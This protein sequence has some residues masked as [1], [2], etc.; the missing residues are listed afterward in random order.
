MFGVTVKQGGPDRRSADTVG[1]HGAGVAA[2]LCGQQEEGGRG[3]A[4]GR[5]G[6]EKKARAMGQPGNGGHWRQGGEGNRGVRDLYAARCEY[7]CAFEEAPSIRGNVGK[8]LP[9]G[10]HVAGLAMC[11]AA[12][13]SH[14]KLRECCAAGHDFIIS[15]KVQADV[16]VPNHVQAPTLRMCNR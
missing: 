3:Q 10:A 7:E 5:A 16:R 12:R 14:P 13:F 1:R 6:D 2:A 15:F 4:A 9:G 8:G 11:G